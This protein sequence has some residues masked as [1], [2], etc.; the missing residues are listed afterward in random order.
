MDIFKEFATDEKLE[1]EGRWVDIGK[2]GRI[3]VARD[4]NQRY[5][6]ELRAN[7][8]KN[9]VA[10]EAG[11]EAADEKAQ[12]LV[13]AA[14][15]KTILLGFEGLK[16]KGENLAYSPENALKL[17]KIKDFERLVDE[18]SRDFDGYKVELE[19]EMGNA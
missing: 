9:K 14:K 3:L 2:G 19:A 17:L 10:L 13:L 7:L 18:Y 5:I 8:E 11:G 6:K 12:E 4:N 16:Y 15:A 1:L